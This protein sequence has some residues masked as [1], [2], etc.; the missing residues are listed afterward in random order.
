[1]KSPLRIIAEKELRDLLR[2]RR[3]IVSMVLIP[4]VAIPLLISAM[5]WMSK[6]SMEKMASSDAKV[7]LIGESY[8]PEILD[9]LR[10]I[11]GLTFVDPKGYG[12]DSLF[13]Q[14]CEAV[15]VLDENL[16][17]AFDRLLL[18]TE[19]YPYPEVRLH[20]DSTVDKANMVATREQDG[21]R[22]W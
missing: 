12:V 7:A 18:S 2:D 19:D 11:P 3:T 17:T 22:K 16:P 14:G 9:N 6:N 1:M 4:I 20:Y 13:A 5:V 8:H 15:V 10:E 21:K